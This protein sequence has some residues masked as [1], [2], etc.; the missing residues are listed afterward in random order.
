MLDNYNLRSKF[1]EFFS[2]TKDQFISQQSSVNFLFKTIRIFQRITTKEYLALNNPNQIFIK[3]CTVFLPKTTATTNRLMTKKILS[4]HIIFRI[5]CTNGS[6]KLR[7]KR[8]MR[9]KTFNYEINYEE[10]KLLKSTITIREAQE[11]E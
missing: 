8:K 7:R 1:K 2:F 6:K 3:F 5:L 4:I 10:T 11:A 9:W